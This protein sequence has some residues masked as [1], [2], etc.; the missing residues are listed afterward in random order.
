MRFLSAHFFS[1]SR[2]LWTAAWPSAK[3]DWTPFSIHFIVCLTSL[4]ITS[5]VQ[6]ASQVELC[7]CLIIH[8]PNTSSLNF[9]KLVKND[10]LLVELCCD[11]S[12]WFLFLS[13]IYLEIFSRKV[14]LI[15]PVILEIS[16]WPVAWVLFIT[17]LKD[18]GGVYFSSFQALLSWHRIAHLQGSLNKFCCPLKWNISVSG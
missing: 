6:T 9:V 3:Q 7:C 18:R 1:L 10:F 14:P 17:F 8:R 13:L 11:H 2:C 16:D 12:S 4:Y 15:L 5:C